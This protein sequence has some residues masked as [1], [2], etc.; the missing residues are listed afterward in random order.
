MRIECYIMH[1]PEVFVQLCSLKTSMAEIV[2]NDLATG[3]CRCH[4][5]VT[6]SLGPSYVG[7]IDGVYLTW[8]A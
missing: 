6:I 1:L 4:E 3:G 8:L 5:M 7:D 2:H